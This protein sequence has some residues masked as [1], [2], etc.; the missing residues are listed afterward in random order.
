MSEIVGLPKDA[1]AS[2]QVLSKMWLCQELYSFLRSIHRL[3]DV[4]TIWLYGGWAGLL[5]FLLFTQRQMQI[6]KI[7][8]FEIDPAAIGQSQII[9]N[10]WEYLKN[11][12]AFLKD[13]N[14]V[15][16]SNFFIFDEYPPTVFI[17][18]S[19]EHFE[20]S[21]WWEN[22]PNGSLVALQGTD[23]QH[24]GSVSAIS[25]S[26]ELKERYHGAWHF[27]GSFNIPYKDWTLQR[28]MVIGRKL[29]H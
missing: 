28:H 22:I 24:E 12:V 4:H 6:R 11:Y 26:T 15:D 27:E 3:Q 20:T 13:A 7:L 5:P 9:L 2:G 29:D 1:F 17:N 21:Q 16:P 10:T 18:T 19:I 14:Q 23:F 8:N 25:S